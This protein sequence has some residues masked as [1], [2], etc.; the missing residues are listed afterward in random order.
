MLAMLTEH[1]NFWEP[2]RAR[3]SHQFRMNLHNPDNHWRWLQIPAPEISW[4]ADILLQVYRLRHA[5]AL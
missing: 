3:H 4:T 1:L 5:Q 2:I